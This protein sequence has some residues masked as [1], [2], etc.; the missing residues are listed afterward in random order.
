MQG[1][2][3]DEGGDWHATALRAAPALLGLAGVQ[4]LGLAL[5]DR[6]WWCE[7]GRA[8]LY[9]G[10]I[11]S[12]HNSQH[13]L[14]PYSL[15]HVSHGLVLYALLAVL[16]WVGR[17]AVSFRLIGG[18]V[19]EMVWE[20][21]ENSPWVVARY[22]EATVSLVYEGDTVA[23]ALGDLGCFVVGFVAASRWGWRWSLGFFAL[24][25]LLMALWIRDNIILNALMLLW[26][27]PAVREWQMPASAG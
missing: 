20:L 18:S 17:R 2:P 19:L 16:P 9:A 21:I 24:F 8:F 22:R 6:L 12:R 4:V 5:M 1:R 7:C 3:L 10:D 23:N 15:S 26:P 27:V 13:V 25:E 11:W 14:D